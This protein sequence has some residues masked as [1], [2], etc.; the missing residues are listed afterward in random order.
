M[1]D[2]LKLSLGQ[3]ASQFKQALFLSNIQLELRQVHLDS[4]KTEISLQPTHSQFPKVLIRVYAYIW[5]H[6]LFYL[7]YRKFPITQ[8]FFF[9]KFY[10]KENKDKANVLITTGQWI[11]SCGERSKGPAW[12]KESSRYMQSMNQMIRGERSRHKRYNNRKD[13]LDEEGGGKGD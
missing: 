8:T 4:Y 12:D 2:A 5:A 3:E 10:G 13:F 1:S 11:I 9:L 7:N 6:L